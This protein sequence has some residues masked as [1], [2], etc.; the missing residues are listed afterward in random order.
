[1]N[2]IAQYCQSLAKLSNKKNL[3]IR[4]LNEY[5]REMDLMYIVHICFIKKHLIINMGIFLPVYCAR[6]FMYGLFTW[7]S[8][9]KKRNA[10][11]KCSAIFT[12]G[13]SE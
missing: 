5:I 1:M 11:K 2:D 7:E 8:N 12:D 13:S 3:V 10:I 6:T 4:Q 9:R